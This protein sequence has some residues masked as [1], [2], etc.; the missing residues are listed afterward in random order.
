M[1][2]I[3]I[4]SLLLVFLVTPTLAASTPPDQAKLRGQIEAIKKAPR[5]PFSQIRWFCNDGTVLPPKAYACGNHGGGVQHGQWTAEVEKLRAD[6]YLIANVLADLDIDPMVGAPGYSDHLNQILI[7]KFLIAVDDGW[8]FRQARYYRGALQAED[9]TEGARKLLL[10]MAGKEAWTDRGFLPLRVG[11]NLL[12]HGADTV[13]VTEIRQLSLALSNQDPK[14]MSI[15]VKIHN[16]PEQSDAKL[17]REYAAKVTD[18]SRKAEYEGLAA[19]IDKGYAG[20][21][22]DNVLQQLQTTLAD[23]PELAK[24]IAAASKTL[25]NSQAPAV[26][27]AVTA[28]LMADIRKRLPRMKGAAKRLAAVDAGLALEVAHFTAATALTKRLPDMTR[29]ECLTWLQESA[30]ALYG[31]GLIS[32]IQQ[33]DLQAAAASLKGNK[34]PLKSYKAVLD[35]LARAPGWGSQSMRFH[36]F[37]SEQKL[38]TIEPLT[39]RFTQDLLRGSPLFFYSGVL[40]Q[41]LRDANQM[42]GLPHELFGKEVGGGLRS[43]NPGL[44]RG[45]LKVSTQGTSANLSQDGIYLL[46]ET[47]AELPPVAGI[48]TAGEGNPLSH[49]QLLARN[50]GIPNVAVDQEMIPALTAHKDRQVILAASPAGAVQLFLDE[51]QLDDMFAKQKAPA[52]LIQPDLEKL[53]LT[54]RDLVPMNQ[55]RASDSGRTVG[56]KAAKLGELHHHYPDAVAQ[57]LAIPFGVFRGLLD[58]PRGSGSQTVFD[59]IVSEYDRLQKMPAGSAPREKATEAFRRQLEQWILTADPGDAFREKLRAGMAEVFGKD[60]SYGVFV[61]SD[62]NVEDLAGFTGAGLNLTVANVVGHDAVLKAISRV[63]ASPFTNRAFAWR[64]AHMEE[65]EHVYTSILLLQSVPVEKS[66][67]MVTRDIDT[68]DMGWLSVVVNEG[69]GGGVDGQAAESLRINTKTGDVRRLAQATATW[70]KVVAPGG[71]VVRELVSGAPEVLARKEIDQLIKLAEGLPQRFPAILD[72]AGQPAPADIE[73][74][75][76]K[77]KLRLFQIRPFL[78]SAQ[79]RQNDYLTGLDKDLADHI[80]KTVKLDEQPL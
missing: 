77:N 25:K 75:F 71:G 47:V 59:W 23:D 1:A 12:D 79:A 41:L 38:T 18:A 35:Y 39:V 6:G 50:L 49:V 22:L 69:V 40:N 33:K 10:G 62:T 37:E 31:S 78:E 58:Q 68:G 54:M 9:E 42:V 30:V 67:V 65:P 29:R 16:A 34:G 4:L 5:G 70:R 21:T 20:A 53:D 2:S 73:F 15:R 66:G 14:F 27:F 57:G 36:F 11:A 44:A 80:D 24:S 61:R 17:V 76:L 72:A 45:T 46:P 52:T 74:G 7:E 64:Q 43:L 13:N 60:G 26:K 19:K 55:L 32:A 8:I 28:Q 63:W 48:L 56:P 3:R 51:G